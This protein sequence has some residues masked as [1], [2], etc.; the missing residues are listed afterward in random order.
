ML[1]Y[2]DFT[3]VKNNEGI[4]TAMGIPVHSMLLKNNV[5]LIVG[6]RGK[7]NKHKS[8]KSKEKSSGIKNIKDSHVGVNNQQY[9]I[10]DGESYDD[11]HE[12]LA[13]PVGLACITQTVC[14]KTNDID[15][16][17]NESIYQLMNNYDTN[18]HKRM[19]HATEL[20]EADDTDVIPDDLYDR[21]IKLAEETT[22][23][24]KLS[25]R[26]KNQKSE[27]GKKSSKNKT[28]KRKK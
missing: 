15:N 17:E 12:H 5:P 13:V 6:G 9:A 11:I 28:Q 19:I 23:P 7:G 20:N 3:V 8:N 4:P 24:K 21:L 14:K 25:R 2:S 26:N 10:D 22:K 18:H 1:D 27:K 16:N